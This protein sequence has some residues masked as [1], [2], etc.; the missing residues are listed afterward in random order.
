[1]PSCGRCVN[2]MHAELWYDTTGKLGSPVPVKT[3]K[4]P[5]GSMQCKNKKKE[6][7]PLTAFLRLG[8]RLHLTS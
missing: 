3:G 1:M 6:A 5:P 2:V 4:G 8:K 7:P